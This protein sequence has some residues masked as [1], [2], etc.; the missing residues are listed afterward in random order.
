MPSSKGLGIKA[1][2]RLGVI[3]PTALYGTEAW[4][5]R[6]AERR[7]LNVVEMKCLKNLVGVSRMDGVNNEVKYHTKR[8]GARGLHTK[9][10]SR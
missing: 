1:Q 8:N 10:T 3:V 2:K 9:V 4:G 6:S 7:K 5:M